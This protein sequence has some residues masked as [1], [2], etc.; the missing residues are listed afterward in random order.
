MLNFDD[1]AKTQLKQLLAGKDSSNTGIL[2]QAQDEQ[3]LE[4]STVELDKLDPKQEPLRDP[5]THF[6]VEFEGFMII[7]NQG[8]QKNLAQAQVSYQDGGMLSGTW[9]Y[10]KPEEIPD[11]V[12][13]GPNLED[14]TTKKVADLLNQEINPGLAMH[15]GR[16]ELLNVL[17]NKVYLRFGGGCQG[18]SMIDA[19][20]KQGIETRLK[21]AIPEIVGVV[22][23]TD[24]AAGTNPFA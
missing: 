2:I 11:A 7:V 22:D 5:I 4:V 14:P 1:T 9:K 13:K 15:G 17:D 19:T 10:Q 6:F 24:H 21:E 20:V 18:C 8:E 16:A 3:S 12:Y 23:E